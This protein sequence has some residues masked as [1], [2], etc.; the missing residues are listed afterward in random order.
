MTLLIAAIRVAFREVFGGVSSNRIYR[1][2]IR[3]MAAN[4][5]ICFD[6][7]RTSRR[8]DARILPPHTAL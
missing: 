3:L 5:A 8:A 7:W 2:L 4:A 6:S 1:R